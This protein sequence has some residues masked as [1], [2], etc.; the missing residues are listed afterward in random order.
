MTGIESAGLMSAIKAG[1]AMS[2]D[3][4]FHADARLKA[5]AM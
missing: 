3:L 1:F 2:Y 5:V 4:L